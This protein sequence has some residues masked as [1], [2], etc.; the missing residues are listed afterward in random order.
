MYGNF[1]TVPFSPS[2]ALLSGVIL[3]LALYFI[4]IQGGRF[5][6]ALILP[7]FVGLAARIALSTANRFFRVAPDG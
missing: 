3:A 5:E 1:I 6:K 2:E 4:F 7:L